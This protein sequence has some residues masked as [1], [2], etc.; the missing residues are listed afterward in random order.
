M[1]VMVLIIIVV[2]IMILMI[3]MMIMM[4][5]V[6]AVTIDKFMGKY[7]AP[8]GSCDPSFLWF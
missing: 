6:G 5:M 1:T 3:V 8:A 2:N 7:S 4:T